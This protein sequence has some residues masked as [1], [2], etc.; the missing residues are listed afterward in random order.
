MYKDSGCKQYYSFKYNFDHV[1]STGTHHCTNSVS[2]KIRI[3][4]LSCCSSTCT[5][6]NLPSARPAVIKEVGGFPL[7]CDSRTAGKRLL[8][9]K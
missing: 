7:A 4:N 3:Q 1:R 6:T 2:F 5:G 8:C 9:S